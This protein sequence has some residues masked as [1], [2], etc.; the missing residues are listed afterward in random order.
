M[1]VA[2]FW[3]DLPALYEYVSQAIARHAD[4]VLAHV[5]HLYTTGA[6]IYFTSLF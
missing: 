6:N 4:M 2:H 1:E 3:K 5:S